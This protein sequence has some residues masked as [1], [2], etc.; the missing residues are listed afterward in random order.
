MIDDLWWDD[1]DAQHIRTRSTRYPGATDIEPDWTLEALKD[2]RRIVR[3]P[4]PK[5][6][7]RAVRLIGYS[8]TAGF[9]LTVI[10]DPV[11]QAGVSAW[12][13]NG[14]DLRAYLEGIDKQ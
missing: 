12:K 10:I 14:A 2:S 3:D 1:E 13:T 6:R 4:D 11:D 9:V 8:P 5:S 7:I